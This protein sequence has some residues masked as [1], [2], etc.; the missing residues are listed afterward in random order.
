MQISKSIK[1]NSWP[2]LPNPGDAP[3]QPIPFQKQIKPLPKNLNFPEKFLPFSPSPKIALELNLNHSWKNFNTYPAHPG[4][5]PKNVYHISQ[6]PW[7]F[8]TFPEKISTPPEIIS[9]NPSRKIPMFPEKNLNPSRKIPNP[10]L[11]K[12]SQPLPKKSQRLSK[13]SQPPPENISTTSEKILTP[14]RKF[15]NPVNY[16]I[17]S[18]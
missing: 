11:P 1:K 6:S 9:I 7:N 12:K 13:N 10:A 15:L 8:S 4:T 16:L 18:P 17:P 3:G 14:P 5:P 2:P